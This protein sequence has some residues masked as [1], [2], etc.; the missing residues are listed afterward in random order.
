[1]T[2]GLNRVTIHATDLAGNTTTTN[3]SYTLNYSGDHTAP[4]L[5]IIWPTN[6]TLISGTNFTL[7]AQVDDDTARVTASIVA[8]NG[9]TNTV[10]LT[11]TD[12]AG[13]ASVTNFSVV[14]NNIGLVIDPISSDQ[15]NQSSVTVTGSI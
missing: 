8:T 6:G 15:L 13:N 2:N 11:V 1:L 4:V 14:G 10:K 9:Q 3:V 5:N 7:Q 12:A